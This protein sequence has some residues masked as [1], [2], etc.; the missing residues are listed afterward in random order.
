MHGLSFET[1]ICYWQ[2]QPGSRHPRRRRGAR[3]RAAARPA[4]RRP[5]NPDRPG[6]F[7]A[8]TRGSG[9]A[10][11]TVAAWQRRPPAAAAGGIGAC[12]RLGRGTAPR[13]RGLPPTRRAAGR[14]GIPSAAADPG[15]R[16][17]PR[18]RGQGAGTAAQLSAWHGASLSLSLSLADSRFFPSLSGASSRGPRPASRLGLARSETRARRAGRSSAGADP[19]PRPTRP[20]D[21]SRPSDRPPARLGREKRGPLRERTSTLRGTSP[22]RAARK[23]PDV[24]EETATRR[25]GRGPDTEAPCSRGAARS[26]AGG[27]TA[28]ERA[29][30]AL[31]PR[32][33]NPVGVFTARLYIHKQ[34]F[35]LAFFS[36]GS[37]PAAPPPGAARGRQPT[38]ATRDRGRHRHLTWLVRTPEGSRGLAAVTQLGTV[39]TPFPQR[40]E[41]RHLACDG[42]RI[43][44]ETALPEHR[45]PPPWL[46]HDRETPEESR[47]AGGPLRRDPKSLIDQARPEGGTART[48]APRPQVLG[49]RQRP[50]GRM[51]P[52]GAADKRIPFSEATGRTGP[53]GWRGDLAPA[54]GE[55][56]PERARKS[57][58]DR[59]TGHRLSPASRRR[60]GG[61]GPGSR[62]GAR[63]SPLTPPPPRNPTS[64]SALS[65]R[66][67]FPGPARLSIARFSVPRLR[68]AS[69]KKTR[70][71][72]AGSPHSA[73]T[74][75]RL[76]RKKIRTRSATQPAGTTAAA[77]ADQTPAGLPQPKR[78]DR[79]SRDQGRARRRRL[80]H[81][82]PGALS[83]SLSLCI[84]FRGRGK[85]NDFNNTGWG[86][87][88]A[89][90]APQLIGRLPSP[91]PLKARLEGR[92][93][94][95]RPT[96]R[97][98]PPFRHTLDTLAKQVGSGERDAATS[99]D[100]WGSRYGQTSPR[101]P[102]PPRERIEHDRG[103]A[104]QQAAIYDDVAGGSQKQRPLGE[105]PQPAATTGLP[106]T[107]RNVTKSLRSEVDLFSPAAARHQGATPTAGGPG[108]G[109]ATPPRVRSPT[110]NHPPPPSPTQARPPHARTLSRAVSPCARRCACPWPCRVCRGRPPMPWPVG[111]APP[112]AISLPGA[113][114]ILSPPPP[115]DG[116]G[117]PALPHQTP[118]RHLQN[119]TRPRPRSLGGQLAR[120][121]RREGEEPA[122]TEEGRALGQQD[123]SLL[124][125][126]GG[127]AGGAVGAAGCGQEV[128]GAG[129]GG[130][131]VRPVGA[132]VGR[133]RLPDSRG[134]KG[135]VPDVRAARLTGARGPAPG[136]GGRASGRGRPLCPVLGADGGAG[137]GT[138]SVRPSVP[139]HERRSSPGP[140]AD[141]RAAGYREPTE[142]PAAL[143]Y[144]YV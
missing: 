65:A 47:P 123:E 64:I 137:G 68:A 113:A 71:G 109:T 93:Q 17:F 77:G 99:A 70:G 27:G 116:W 51:R 127:R 76:K 72:R 42:K 6:S 84:G 22:H 10:D 38:G 85:G 13:A 5:A 75:A 95:A 86:R 32:I 126:R 46:P 12:R 67:G 53:P 56:R 34:P 20:A 7:T 108:A 107:C 97:P 112:S 63:H 69:G 29:D 83:L 25:G 103:R 122:D 57:A 37:A 73:R 8:P 80:A 87:G 66:L 139:N 118:R 141:G 98:P 128:G 106:G 111:G 11:A 117:R 143:R 14:R 28:M 26:A 33:R 114:C 54:A 120:R 9:I 124:Q 129:V 144:R 45:T 55:T 135:R 48:R 41:G 52:R 19:P 40:R 132:Q 91:S 81:D 94:A 78:L 1:S 59:A 60:H 110:D 2:D 79:L 136:H 140:P 119:F 61:R 133:L 23:A 90:P 35:S 30:R 16:P 43:G 125:R 82:T 142:A 121:R 36:R 50:P 21:R 131:S 130:L 100:P 104:P 88:A 92:G 49:Q 105:L 134:G 24:L 44:K 101:P 115:I 89:T 4:G 15:G 102:A 18:R 3:E 58:T 74:P 138:A 62:G 39:K 31:S 96:A